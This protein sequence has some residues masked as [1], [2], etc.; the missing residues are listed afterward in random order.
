MKNSL[1]QSFEEVMNRG[2][3]QPENLISHSEKIKSSEEEDDEI[4]IQ[5]DQRGK[6]LSRDSDD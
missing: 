1:Y 5:S 2:K 6:P 3:P 4:I